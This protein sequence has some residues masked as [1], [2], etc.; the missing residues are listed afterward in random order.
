MAGP[1]VEPGRVVGLGA[2]CDLRPPHSAAARDRSFSVAEFATLEDGRRVTLHEAR[3]FTLGARSTG[4]PGPQELRE[5]LTLEHLTRNVLNVVL[6][7]DDE[8]GEEHPWDWLAGL[9][10]ERGLN[11]TA[12]DLRDLPYEVVFTD[13]LRRWLSAS[14]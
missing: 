8:S 10:R 3:G 2:V 1:P 13:E 14:Y 7:D 12:D 6:P 9:A 11:V 4:E 5:H